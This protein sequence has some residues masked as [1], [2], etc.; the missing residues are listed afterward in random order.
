MPTVEEAYYVYVVELSPNYSSLQAESQIIRPPAS[1][2]SSG[3]KGQRYR[4]DVYVG[5]S[6][7]RPEQRFQKHLHQQ[8][9]SRHVRR[10]G[11][12]LRPDLYAGMNPIRTRDQAKAAEQRLRDRLERRGYR[13]YGSCS[14]RETRECWL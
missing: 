12:R 3:D 14:P 6:A 13:V 5:Y 2:R 4:P 7:L 11:V 8:K 1:R 9:G 10:R